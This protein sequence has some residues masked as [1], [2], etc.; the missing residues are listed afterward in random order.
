MDV[1]LL[2]RG[3]AVRQAI[4][5]C[6]ACPLSAQASPVP[7]NGPPNPRFAVVGEAPGVTENRRGAPFMGQSGRLI[8][9]LM[10]EAG[11]EATEGL[12]LNVVSCWPY[13]PPSTE[14]QQACRPHFDAQ[15]ELAGTEWVLAV[16]GV[17]LGAFAYDGHLTRL[18]GCFLAVDGRWVMPVWHPAYLLR[19][20]QRW[21]QEKVVNALKGFW[22]AVNRQV[23]P[24]WLAGDS[25]VACDRK[26][27]V[28]DER[29]MP[30][31]K[32]H[33]KL[34]GARKRRTRRQMKAAWIAAQGVL[35]DG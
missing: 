22:A 14:H 34:I 4:R 32:A 26:A 6:T 23:A 25:C 15:L 9:R 13:G 10:A 5:S 3:V 30:Y 11:V 28:W 2:R 8:R 31:C 27:T 18:H 20:R 17:A 1:E 35:W 7:C 21:Q 33:E 19:N 29:Q 24:E 12:W 16:G